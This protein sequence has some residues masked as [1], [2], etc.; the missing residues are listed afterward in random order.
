MRMDPRP[1]A[2]TCTSTARPDRF[3]L[4]KGWSWIGGIVAAA[5]LLG[6]TSPA[7]AIPVFARKYGTSCVTCHTVYPKLTPFGE[8]F[9]RNGFRFPG[10]DSD[11]VKQDPVPL[12]QEAQ[13]QMFPDSVWPGTLP[14]SVP[15]AVGFNGQV[16]GHPSKTSGSATA[17]NGARFSLGGLIQEGH[18]WTAGS[19]DDKTT[20]FG[21]M[22]FGTDGSV[23]IEHARVLFNDLVGPKHLLNISV[24]KQF[25]TLSSF[26]PHSSYVADVLIP[27][28]SVSALYG[29]TDPSWNI[30]DKYNTIELTS[31]V[32]GRFNLSLG[33]NAGANN[34]VALSNNVY[35]HA[36]Y[37]I[38]GMRLDGEGSAGP[39]DPMKPWAERALTIDVFAS[40][41]ESRFNI[42]DTTA[43]PPAPAAMDDTILTFGAA[44]RAQWNSLE[45]NAGV[46]Q[47]RHDHVLATGS[48]VH[49]LSQYEELSYVVFPCFVPAVRV[50]VSQVQPTGGSSIHDVRII[51]GLA[52]LVRPNLKLSLIGLIEQA[53]GAPDGGWGAAGGFASPTTG[54]VT[55]VESII[56]NIAF[57]F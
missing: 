29:S 44:I 38:G 26:G 21:E 23:D 1:Q 42:N 46:Y 12:G 14:S 39:D 31:I 57:A 45:L 43:T 7:S 15:L 10:V 34:S 19:F 35:A 47:E 32:S 3:S 33:V 11:M 5:I 54:S 49:A 20:F 6:W 36:G 2:Q 41:A 55:E 50:E 8:A 17:D 4:G 18:L 40:H 56:G 22:T 13:K 28:L 37:K 52:F 16:V 25:A 30:A 27:P 48:G 24:G 9:R 51:P 53:N